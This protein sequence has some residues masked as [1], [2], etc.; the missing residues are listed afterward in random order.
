MVLSST[1]KT[2]WHI[3]MQN[4]R[5]IFQQ[6]TRPTLKIE[7]RPFSLHTFNAQFEIEFLDLCGNVCPYL[8]T[9]AE[10]MIPK[11]YWNNTIQSD[12]IDG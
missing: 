11:S 3:L 7:T 9:A 10:T 1:V 5:V 8:G 12:G 4:L 6:I 2:T